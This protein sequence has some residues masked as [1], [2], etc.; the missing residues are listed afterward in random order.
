MK[1]LTFLCFIPARRVLLRP[2][3]LKHR[4]LDEDDSQN[5]PCNRVNATKLQQ[6]RI[7]VFPKEL[8]G[9]IPNFHI[10]VSVS[11]LYIPRIGPHIFQRQTDHGNISIA[12]RHMNEA[13]QFLFKEY[14]FLIFGIVSLQCMKKFPNHM[15]LGSFETADH[16]QF[17]KST[18]HK[19]DQFHLKFSSVQAHVLGHWATFFP[20][21][22]KCQF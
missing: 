21:S 15:E 6:N 8:R 9:L 13:A 20:F 17:M 18:E 5:P 11:D 2:L 14:L 10:Q 4:S 19:H 7:Y 1:V 3:L 22:L 16:Q 12:H